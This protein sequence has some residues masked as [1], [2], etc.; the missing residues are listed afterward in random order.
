MIEY[1]HTWG[2]ERVFF[3]DHEGQMQRIPAAWT[4]VMGEDPFVVV[5]AGRSPLRVENLLQLADLI[6]CLNKEV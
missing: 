3:L 4:D 2:E 6:E 1:R 5:A